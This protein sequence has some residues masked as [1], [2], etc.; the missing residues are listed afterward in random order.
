MFGDVA[1]A[2]SHNAVWFG[3]Y[4]YNVRRKIT[5]PTV[6][7]VLNELRQLL[8]KEDARLDDVGS[9]IELD[10]RTA[11]QVLRLI[12]SPSYKNAHRDNNIKSAVR[13]IGLRT[14]QTLVETS[15]MNRL[16]ETRDTRLKPLLVQISRHSVACAVTMRARAEM[17]SSSVMDKLLVK[18]KTEFHSIVDSLT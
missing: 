12:N 10:Q 9:L 11:T 7:G 18:L 17:L 2:L 6:G 4:L 3:A 8:R 15:F 13:R 1:S 16:H 14:V 5:L